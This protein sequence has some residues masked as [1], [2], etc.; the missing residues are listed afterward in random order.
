MLKNMHLSIQDL[1]KLNLFTFFSGTPF[2]VFR[3]AMPFIAH[4]GK[5]VVSKK[6][7]H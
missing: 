7:K 5:Y 3:A 4:V 2:G 6:V 1:A